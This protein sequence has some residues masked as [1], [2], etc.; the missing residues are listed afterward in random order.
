[1][2]G[3]V[4]LPNQ[5]V[6]CLT[7]DDQNRLIAGVDVFVGQGQA[8]IARFRQNGTFDPSFGT[9]GV[10]HVLLGQGSG[11][12][13]FDQVAVQS[14]GR[15]LGAATHVFHQPNLVAVARLLP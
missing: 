10:T 5:I 1:M 4:V 15:I 12:F 13:Q 2:N 8:T 9:G 14:N 7:L 11:G 3:Q 6:N